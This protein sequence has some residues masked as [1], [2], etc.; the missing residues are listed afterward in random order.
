MGNDRIYHLSSIMTLSNSCLLSNILHQTSLHLSSVR[1][2]NLK[3]IDKCFDTK[4][5]L[6][7]NNV[8]LLIDVLSCLNSYS[9]LEV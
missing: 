7:G 9:N 6:K 8:I 1:E 4:T 2:R 3:Q 5:D